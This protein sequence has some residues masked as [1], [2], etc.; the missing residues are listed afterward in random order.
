MSNMKDYAM[1]LDDRGVATWS[2]EIDELIVPEGVNIYTPELVDDYKTD[3]KWHDVDDEDMIIDDEDD[4]VVI[5]DG[6]DDEELNI[7]LTGIQRG[8]L[9]GVLRSIVD[10][11]PDSGAINDLGTDELVNLWEVLQEIENPMETQPTAAEHFDDPDEG[12]RQLEFWMNAD[13]ITGDAENHLQKE[14]LNGELV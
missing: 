13:G 10:P 5:D 9:V 4:G 14:Y 6:D 1:W 2:N 7:T 3:K 8:V 12:G 11:D